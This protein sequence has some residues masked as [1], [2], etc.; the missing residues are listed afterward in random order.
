MTTRQDKPALVPPVAGAVAAVNA[1]TKPFNRKDPILCDGKAIP[2]WQWWALQIAWSA[3]A[4]FCASLIIMSLYY[5]ITQVRYHVMI[6]GH[7]YVYWLKPAWDRLLDRQVG[8]QKWDLSR[9]LGRNLLDPVLAT[10]FVKS[11]L[12][13]WK[14]HPDSRAPMWYV[15]LSPLIVFTAALALIIPFCWVVFWGVPAIGNHIPITVVQICGGI[16]IG[17]II[18]RVYAPAGRTIQGYFV[19]RQEFKYLA[20]GNARKHA[21]AR[22]LPPMVQELYWHDLTDDKYPSKP[23][24]WVKFIIPVFAAFCIAAVVFGGIVKFGVAPGHLDWFAGSYR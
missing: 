10:L 13:N 22:W 21:P 19:D 23:G 1:V 20:D 17:Q 4:A 15:A 24:S 6:D 7:E 18:H 8:T 5:L 11:L 2:H 14:H 12:A 16:L 3:I 9:H